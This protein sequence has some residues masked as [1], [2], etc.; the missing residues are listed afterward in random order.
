MAETRLQAECREL[1]AFYDER[2]KDWTSA[3]AFTLCLRLFGKDFMIGRR[4]EGYYIVRH[5]YRSKA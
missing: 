1:I 5:K 3:L 2:G 4:E